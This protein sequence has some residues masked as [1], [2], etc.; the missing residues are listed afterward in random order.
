[1]FICTGF[2]YKCILLLSADLCIC[3]S[4]KEQLHRLLLTFFFCG[5]AGEGLYVYNDIMVTMYIRDLIYVCLDVRVVGT[6]RIHQR[7]L[8]GNERY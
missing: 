1:M 6:C 4:K 2:P 3:S 7:S 5:G 8:K